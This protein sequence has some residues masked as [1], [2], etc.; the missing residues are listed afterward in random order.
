VCPVSPRLTVPSYSVRGA[1]V[2]GLGPLVCVPGGPMRDPV[3][4]GDLGGLPTRRQ[5]IVLSL[6][7]TG[8]SAKPADR[9]TYRADRQVGDVEALRAH[10]GLETLDLLGHSAGAA[11]AILYAAAHPERVGHLT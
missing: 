7:G 6:R 11:I 4:L 3:Y 9:Q 10:L 1:A 2:P 8:E 5:L